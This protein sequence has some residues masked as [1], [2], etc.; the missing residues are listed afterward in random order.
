MHTHSFDRCY[1][2]TKFI[3]PSIGDIKFSKLNYDN[4]CTYLDNK[5]THSTE[6]RKHMLDLMAFLQKY[7][8]ICNVLQ[9]VDKII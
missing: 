5:N 7:R 1:I 2:I 3:L 8:T 4:I 9:K 6:T